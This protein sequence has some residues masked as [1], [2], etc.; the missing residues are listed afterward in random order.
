MRKFAMSFGVSGFLMAMANVAVAA[1]IRVL[2]G[3]AVGAP[4]QALAAE[5]TKQTGHLVKFTSTNP[6]IIQQKID[7]GEAFE[8]YV[9]PAAF[10]RTAEKANKVAPGTSRHVAKVGVGVAARADGPKY[11]FSTPEAFKKMLLDAKKVAFSDASTGGLSA[12]S[13]AKV[14]D[15]LGVADVVKAKAVTQGNG[16]E[17][18]GK[19]EVD[20]GLYNVSEIPRAPNVV[21]AGRLPAAIQ[22]W[23]E[24]DAA[25]PI[26]NAAPEPAKALLAFMTDPQARAKWDASG[27]DMAGN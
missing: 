6:A 25:I 14:L 18:V 3:N 11:D 22:A 17:M 19:A 16:Q 7:A 1:E 21:M 24:Y 10:L 9:I 5:F 4:Q 2:T 12:L 13:V 20:F 23:L 8:L 26:G 15:N 27:I